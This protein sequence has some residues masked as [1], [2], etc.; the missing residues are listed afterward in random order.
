MR[1]SVHA[2]LTTILALV[3]AGI[4]LA[5]GP[6]AAAASFSDEFQ[7]PGLGSRWSWYNE[8]PPAWSLSAHPGFLR[9]SGVSEMVNDCGPVENILLE[10]PPAGDWQISVRLIVKGS[11]NY[12]QGGIVAFRDVNN[13][14]KVDLLYNSNMG[15]GAVEFVKE[16][17]G[18]FPS[19]WAHQTA[20]ISKPMVLRLA[21]V[22]SQ[23]SA[24]MSQGRAS[25]SL[26]A[27]SVT[28]LGS[29]KVGLFAFAGCNTGAPPVTVDFDYFRLVRK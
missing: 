22:G 26:G 2:R 23:L 12:Q 29:F 18:V 15:G 9:I 4:A 6:A 16:T 28:G 27:V 8:H 3:L 7:G 20:N 24:S 17:G 13:Y 14:A 11:H 1:R 5:A 25:R 21:R 19:A 10:K